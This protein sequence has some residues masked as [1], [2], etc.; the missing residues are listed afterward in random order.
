MLP[1]WCVVFSVA[2]RLG[3]GGRYAWGVLKGKARPNPVT[4]FLWGVTPIITL[5]ASLPQGFN[6]QSIVLLALGASPLVT[7][8]LAVRRQGIRCYLTPLTIGCAAVAVFGIILWQTLSRPELAVL[9]SIVA[10]TFAGLPTM[11][12]SYNDP[13]SEYALPYLLSILSM[14]VTLLTV[15]T[16]TFTVF[17]F[18]LYMLLSNVVLFALAALPIRSIIRRA[19]QQTPLTAE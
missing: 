16:W 17:A 9:C 4:W 14:A 18:P 19:R 13:N 11:H 1:A 5:F 2:I 12:K 6:G 3:G 10:D 8:Y 15:Q 7:C